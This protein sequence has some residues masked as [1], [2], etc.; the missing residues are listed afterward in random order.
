MAKCT[1]GW[2]FA[3]G[4]NL[5]ASISIGLSTDN[6]EIQSNATWALKNISHFLRPKIKC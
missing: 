6:L 5:F 2:L 1:I 4:A 3:D